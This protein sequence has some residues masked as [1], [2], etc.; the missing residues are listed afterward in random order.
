MGGRPSFCFSARLRRSVE[1][2]EALAL[3]SSTSERNS[4]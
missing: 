3:D 1:G 4:E 2:Q